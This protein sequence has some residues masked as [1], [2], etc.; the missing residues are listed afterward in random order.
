V[1]ANLPH[2]YQDSITQDIVTSGFPVSQ[3]TYCELLYHPFNKSVLP[4]AIVVPEDLT[5]TKVAINPQSINS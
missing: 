3:D 4:T 2:P 1:V 5:I